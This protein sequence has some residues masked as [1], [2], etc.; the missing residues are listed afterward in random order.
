MKALFSVLLVA[1]IFSSCSKSADPAVIEDLNKQFIGAWNNK[2]SDKVISFLAE[3]VDF[4]QGDVHFKG[5]SEVSQKWV[6]ETLPTISDLKTNVVSS[7]VDAQ[8][9]YQ[10]GTFSVDVLPDGPNRP[11]GFGEGNFIFVWKKDPDNSWKLSYAQLEDLPVQ[12]KN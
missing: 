8:T 12:V 2:E 6:R 7:T 9:A 1:A 4:L 11:R 10:A 5:K 3:D